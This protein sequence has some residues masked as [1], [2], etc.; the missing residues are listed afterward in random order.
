MAIHPADQ[1]SA[2]SETDECELEQTPAGVPQNPAQSSDHP[3]LVALEEETRRRLE[4]ESTLQDSEARYRLLY[5]NNPTMY[6]TLSPDGTVVSVNQFGATQLGYQPQDLIGQSVLSVF[7]SEE[8]AAVLEQLTVCTASPLKVFQWEIQKVRKDGTTLW[9]K[10]RAQ[11]VMDH[12]GQILLLVVCEDITERRLTEDYMRESEERWRALFEHAGVGIAQLSLNEQFLRVN[13]RL[14]E[15]LGYSSKTMLRRRCQDFVH[16]DDLSVTQGQL[17]ELLIGKYPSFSMETRWHRSDDAWVWV[18]LTVSLVRNASST[19]AYL[20]AVIQNIGDRKN[21]EEA[22]Q[23]SETR[24]RQ[25]AETIEEVVWSADAASGKALYISPAYERVWGRTCASLYDNPE[26]F[27]DSI[28]PDDRGGV[29]AALGKH[30]GI[31]FDQEY[32]IVRP[33]GAVRWIWDRGFPVRDPGTGH[34]THYVGVALD[35]TERRQAGEALRLSESAIR[36]LHEITSRKAV[37]FD[38]QIRELL[39]LGRRRFQLPIA[40]FTTLKGE[41][42]ELTA[43]RSDRPMM[44]EGTLLP[45]CSICTETLKKNSTITI[46]HLGNSEW[47]D[48]SACFFFEFESYLGT[49]L[50]VDGQT[51]GTICFMDYKPYRGRFSEADKDFLLLMARWITHELERQNSDLVLQ[52]Q[53]EALR[54]S[55]ERFSKAFRSSPYPMIVTDL[56]TGRC[57]EVNEASLQAFGF[58]RHEVIGKCTLTLGL[59]PNPAEGQKL[60]DRLTTEGSLQ[61]LDMTIYT[62][63]HSERRFLISC[64]LIELN[65]TRCMVAVGTD[66]TEQRRAEEAL[67]RSEQAVRQAFEDRERLSQDLH[68]NLLQSLYAVGMGLELTRQRIQRISRTNAKRLEQSVGQLNNVIREVRTFISHVQPPM[69]L[70]Q[71]VGDALRTLAGS[72][73]ATGAGVISVSVDDEISLRFSA[74][75]RTHLLAI[76]KEALSNSI[77]HTKAD[78]R[79]VTLRRQGNKIRLQVIDNGR[80]FLPSRRQTQGMGLQ[81]MRARARKLRGR[82]AITSVLT[83]GTTVTLTIPST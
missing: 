24:F 68:D 12:V 19:P 5:D 71:T 27:L 23:K 63:T 54:A 17:N 40:A 58:E 35:F 3:N 33:D 20:I 38:Q 70:E 32:R 28:H 4:I 8:H 65:K 51:F 59:W 46:E 9:V 22:L 30:R 13:S 43:I 41:Q 11:A 80:G 78:R 15:T 61:N 34:V 47:K 52:N 77:R 45:Q 79:M 18:D 83:Q 44:G 81:N 10:E 53:E 31:P 36:E 39:D 66:I 62:K 69:V 56:E 75:Q 26:S 14:C 67:R 82:I 25:I 64:E 74:E 48:G 6:F 55:E 72:F 60:I 76:A 50:L 16:P 73:M 49:S 29:L 42:L 37:S 7:K 57:L 2:S 1:A 21:A